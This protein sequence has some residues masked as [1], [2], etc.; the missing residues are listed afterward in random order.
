MMNMIYYIYFNQ[1]QT[2]PLSLEEVG[3]YKITPTTKVWREDRERWKEAKDF[4]ELHAFFPKTPPPLPIVPPPL[5][6]TS[7]LP[8]ERKFRK[9]KS[10]AVWG[11]VSIVLGIPLLM[12][13]GAGGFCIMF[14]ILQLVQPR[15]PLVCHKDY[16]LCKVLP[17]SGTKRIEYSAIQRIDYSHNKMV[18]HY[19]SKKVSVRKNL[20]CKE[21]WPSIVSLFKTIR[22]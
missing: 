6:G 12:L 21:E 20:F 8:E 11:I 15:Y 17:L 2:G 18:I 3:N 7:P 16:L 19:L 9:N 1:Q 10:I 4:E 13:G 22:P 5:E 14:G